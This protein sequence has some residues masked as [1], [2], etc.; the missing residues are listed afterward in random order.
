MIVYRPEPKEFPT[1]IKMGA[2]MWEES[3][4]YSTDEYDEEA[5]QKLGEALYSH[6]DG[7]VLA[8]KESHDSAPFGMMVGQAVPY[9]FAPSKKMAIDFLVYV[10]PE[11]RGTS[12][13]FRLLKAFESWARNKGVHE[14]R[15]GV[16]TGVEPERTAKLYRKLGFKNVGGIFTK[17]L[18]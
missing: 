10:A 7:V 16:S 18:N 6:P 1:L 5:L 9:F 13:A 11:K 3:N 2:G 4:F 8:V 12:A 17:P 14:M 15:L